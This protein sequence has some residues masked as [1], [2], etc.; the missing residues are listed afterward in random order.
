MSNTYEAAATRDGRWWMIHIPAIDGLIQA[1]HFGEI[2][3]M[4]RSL[5]AITTGAPPDSIVVE[6]R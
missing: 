6:I 4:A 3:E 5:I 2:V 1:R